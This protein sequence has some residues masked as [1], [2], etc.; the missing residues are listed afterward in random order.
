MAIETPNME[1]LIPSVNDTDYPSSVST[2]FTNIDRHDHSTGK[3]VQVVSAGIADG[4]IA[5]AKL[6]DAS[7]STAKLIDASVTQ[8][9]RAALGQ[10]LSS[11]ANF[12]TS[13]TSYVDVT[14]LT[15]TI[16]TTGRPV[17][18]A[19]I[20]DGSSNEGYAG[21]VMGG[22]PGAFDALFKILEGS[23]TIAAC[24]IVGSTTNT[25][26]GV[27]V[28]SFQTIRIVSAGTYTYKVQAAV[29]PTA[30]AGQLAAVRFAKLIA[31]EL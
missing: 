19:V 27:P 8:A 6:A 14:N 11:S 16:T 7:V 4:A 25:I 1:L 15:V 5:T 23:T 28:S 21:A 17:L 31:Y 3:G 12:T 10:Q 24:N 29:G 13:N 18:I 2:S 26:A 22:G 20:P 30:A 9:K